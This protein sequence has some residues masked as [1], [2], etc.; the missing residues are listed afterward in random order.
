MDEIPVLLRTSQTGMTEQ[1]RTSQIGMT[2]VSLCLTNRNDEGETLQ[3]IVL[4]C[5]S[6]ISSNRSLQVGFIELMRFSLNDRFHFFI[7]FS[8]SMASRIV[9]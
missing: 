3:T 9:S 2:V 6:S 7:R 1:T 8:C 5:M 4:Y